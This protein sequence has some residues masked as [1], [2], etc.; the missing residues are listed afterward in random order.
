MDTMEDEKRSNDQSTQENHE[1]D[2]L[3]SRSKGTY[4]TIIMTDDVWSTC[5][6]NPWNWRTVKKWMVMSSVGFYGFLA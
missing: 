5:P 1:G 3:D 2:I 6:E 4:E